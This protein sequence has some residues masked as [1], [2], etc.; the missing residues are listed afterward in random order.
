MS[1]RKELTKTVMVLKLVVL[2]AFDDV[3]CDDECFI[4][5]KLNLAGSTIVSRKKRRSG[6]NA[7]F[8][9]VTDQ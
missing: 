1:G 7:V 5:S 8:E 9:L 4:K 2:A 6:R 3:F